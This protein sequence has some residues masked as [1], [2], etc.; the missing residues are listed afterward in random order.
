VGCVAHHRAAVSLFDGDTE[1]AK[2]SHF[3]PQVGRELVRSVD[4]GGSRRNF[5]GRKISHRGPQHVDVFAE[6]KTQPRQLERR[7]SAGGLAR[8][9]SN[10]TVPV[11]I[12][13][14]RCGVSADGSVARSTGI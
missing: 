1:Q 5:S 8:E 10:R 9:I 11:G 14:D 13:H 2:R 6:T 3:S 7:N 12:G 4:V